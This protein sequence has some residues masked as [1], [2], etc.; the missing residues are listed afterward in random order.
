MI[1]S[2]LMYTT[3]EGGKQYR[4]E[5]RARAG[6]GTGE[7]HYR[8]VVRDRDGNVVRDES[9]DEGPGF[10]GTRPELPLHIDKNAEMTHV[11][12]TDATAQVTQPHG[13][14][15]G[16]GLRAMA[17]LRGALKIKPQR[18]KRRGKCRRHKKL[19][20]THPGC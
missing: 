7:T 14:Y 18:F 6:S 19:Q 1:S 10:S 15:S 20:C 4:V 8:R 5:L 16:E 11:F 3:G 12:T 9:W 17:Q 13:S 2:G